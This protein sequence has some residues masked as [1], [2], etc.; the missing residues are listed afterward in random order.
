MESKLKETVIREFYPFYNN[1]LQ[2]FCFLLY[3]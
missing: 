2:S 3:G 1:I